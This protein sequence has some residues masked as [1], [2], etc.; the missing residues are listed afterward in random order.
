MGMLIKVT[1]EPRYL[2]VI[3]SGHF[4]LAEAERTFLQVIDAVALHKTDKVLF[5]GRDVIGEPTIIQRFYYGDF[6]ARIVARY[7]AESGNPW[8]QFAYV[9]EE[10]VLDPNRFGEKVARNRG[11][12][13]KVFDNLEEAFTWLELEFIESDEG[14]T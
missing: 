11:M 13:M 3:S 5:D 12:N 1:A 14:D 4:T 6:A 8:P 9:L 10:P 2:R 7:A